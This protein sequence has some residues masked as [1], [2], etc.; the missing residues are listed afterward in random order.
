MPLVSIVQLVVAGSTR[1]SQPA[2]AKA[3]GSGFDESSGSRSRVWIA[4]R[5]RRSAVATASSVS[6]SSPTAAKRR[7]YQLAYPRAVPSATARNS[8]LSCSRPF[9]CSASSSPAG[10]LWRASSRNQARRS[11]RQDWA[12]RSSRPHAACSTESQSRCNSTLTAGALLPPVVVPFQSGAKVEVD[13][14]PHPLD[15]L[16]LRG[17][18]SALALIDREGALDFEGMERTVGALAAALAA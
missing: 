9:A 18:S 10:G 8:Q 16:T 1:V 3:R 7:L 14:T 2:D 6:G 17:A 13:P 4:G 5:W 11:K 15:H 12:E